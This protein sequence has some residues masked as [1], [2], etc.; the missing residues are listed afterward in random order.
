MSSEHE[1]NEDCPCFV[2]RYKRYARLLLIS[3]R[4]AIEA[5]QARVKELEDEL[6][7]YEHESETIQEVKNENARLRQALKDIEEGHVIVRGDRVMESISKFAG[8]A[9]AEE[10]IKEKY[11][12]VSH[13][14][15]VKNQKRAASV[16]FED[17]ELE[18]LNKENKDF[19]RRLAPKLYGEIKNC[20]EENAR[21]REAIVTGQKN[22][23]TLLDRSDAEIIALEEENTRLIEEV[24]AM[25]KLAAKWQA[26]FARVE[27]EK[28]YL[29]RAKETFFE[30]NVLLSERL[31]IYSE[32][33][34]RDSDRIKKLQRVVDAAREWEIHMDEDEPL[35]LAF[36]D[37]DGEKCAKCGLSR[38]SIGHDLSK[39]PYECHNK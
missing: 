13:E 15:F 24:A 20:H 17:G 11:N 19:R 16:A 18:R 9:A 32:Q 33:Q 5:L 8:K 1:Y 29:Y 26:E 3:D 27:D 37:M 38:L 39:E 6:R 23:R 25:D 21:L 4:K 28:T 2:C 12:P 7:R 31:K 10:E 30:E 35:V 36:R 14:N 34:L 22:T